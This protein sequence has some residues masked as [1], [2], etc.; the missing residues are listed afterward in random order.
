MASKP[1]IATKQNKAVQQEKKA[2]SAHQKKIGGS[3][4]TKPHVFKKINPSELPVIDINCGGNISHIK[5]ALTAYCQKELGAIS[6]I[7]IEG[8]YQD[9]ITVSYDPKSLDSDNDPLG[10]NK[11]RVI[12]KMKQADSDNAAYEKS[13]AKLF[14]ILSSMTTKEVDE[15]LSIHRSHLASDPT[16]TNSS[17]TA[18]STAA[19]DL[20]DSPPNVTAFINCPLTLWKD[21]VHVVT[22]KTAGNKRIDQDKVTVDFATM[23]QRQSESLS[24]FHHR[25]SHTVDSYEMLGLEKP[26]A[27][28]QAMR[29]IQGLDG[30]R[31]A[32]MQ[33][34]FANELHNGRDLYPTDLPTAVLKASRWMVSGRSTQ[35]PMRA[36]A[37]AKGGKD[38][39]GGKDKPKPQPKTDDKEKTSVKCEFCSR[40]GHVMTSC[41]KFKDA[42]TAATAATEEKSKHHAG[43]RKGTTMIARSSYKT[44]DSDDEEHHFLVNVHIQSRASSVLTASTRSA[45]RKT[46]IVL[47]TGANGSLF[48][49][50]SLLHNLDTQEEVTFD[51]I[52]GVLSTDTVGEFL[53]LCRA[54]VHRDAIANILSFSQL[55]QLGISIAYD[56]GENPDDDSFTILHDSG[57]LK[58]T[59]RENG[60]YV[61]DT[62]ASA[63]RTCL[64]T[65]VADNEALYSRRE[66]IRARE[67]R[68]LQRRMANP[69]DAKLIKA[70]AS[71]TIQ[72]TTVTPS[73]VT[74][75]TA[76]YGPS[77]EAIKGRTTTTHALPFPQE[78]SPRVTAEQK[79]Y[80]DIFFAAGCAF[81][82]SIVHPIGHIICSYLDKTDTPTLRRAL[83]T[84]LG[85][86]GQRRISIRHI[87]SD[88]EKG[89]LCMGQDFAGAGITLHLAGPGMHVHTVERAIRTI[90]EGVRGLLAGLPYPCPK[91]I[92]TH[93]IPFVAYRTNM[94]PSSTRTDNIPPFQL[95]FN[96]HINANI[97]CQ[98]EFGAYYQV[99]VRT[100]DNT[101]A[102][103]TLGAIGIGQSG[104]GTGTCTFYGLHN[105]AIFRAN[106]FR[107]LPMP[108]EVI[109][110]LT[111]LAAADKV[112]IP[113]DPIFQISA[114]TNDEVPD[115]SSDPSPSSPV[116]AEDNHQDLTPL[117]TPIPDRAPSPLPTTHRADD[118]PSPTHENVRIELDRRGDTPT[119]A[120]DITHEISEPQDDVPAPDERDTPLAADPPYNT[121]E[122]EPA[123]AVPMPSAKPPPMYVHPTRVR[124]PPEKLNLYGVYHMTAKRALKENPDGALP[125]IRQELETLLR[126]RVFHGRDYA[127]LTDPQRKS[128]IRSQMNVTQKY[129]P[130][131]DGNGRVKDK[132]KARLVGGGDG[133]DRN[134]YSRIDTSSPT[135]STSAILIIAQLAAA[136]RRHVI[137]LDI[138]SAYLNAKMPKDD[139]NKLVFMAIASNMADILI[140]LEPSY[141]RFQRSNGTI[142]VELDQA[143]YGCIES[144]LLWYKELSSFL[145]SIGFA[146]NPYEK[147][148][149]NK[150]ESGHQTTIA[151]YV[152]DLLITSTRPS[153][154]EAVVVALRD[155][156]KELK[157]TPGKIHNYL[158][159]V[160]DFSKPP[161]VIINQTGMI[162]DIISKVRAT[163]H[164]N[165]PSTD[166]K[167]PSIEQ[168]FESS[169]DSPLLSEEHKATFHSVVAKFNFVTCRARPD[170]L[171]PLSYLMKR[172]LKPTEED[173]R[174]LARYIAYAASTTD[175]PLRLGC[176]LPPRVNV[177]IDA[178]F[179]THPDMK[180]H[181]GVCITLGT[182]AYY[183]KSTTQKLN[184][185]SSCEAELVALAKGL[186]Q[187]LWSSYFIENQGYPSAPVT[188]LQDNQST[189]RLVENGG[190]TSELSRHIR[191][192][193]FWMRDLLIKNIISVVY[194]PT[195][196][197]IAD[198]MTKPL[199]GSLFRTMRDRIMGTAPCPMTKG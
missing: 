183:S 10:L 145:G 57:N 184:T 163:G 93:M 34:S 195:E 190:P 30:S 165:I 14:G 66:V 143:L 138:G 122:V 172:V 128:I 97:D 20:K 127:T 43:P 90:K 91:S 72:N 199:Q 39:K 55:R 22:T 185:T 53:G 32:T 130:S 126:K 167:S 193:F 196:S 123:S 174:K 154:A 164:F 162:E 61:H 102:P 103:R 109:A 21:I 173:G 18:T 25:M 166:P 80:V 151:I 179:A 23:R 153:H 107:L 59:H 113:K 134:L 125:V 101:V 36:L 116:P 139:P 137:S 78:D 192:G 115:S 31:Y 48:K 120:D 152:D 112:K 157:V 9:E 117:D 51:G 58:F 186:Q 44:Q 100:P 140:D 155:K 175:L 35:E 114:L 135:A 87:Y 49:N 159:M 106:T 33:T 160:M 118:L 150:E 60:L 148:I 69:P 11:A 149:L 28:T 68:Q 82:I 169:P 178:S 74:R 40:T 54:H 73:D 71:G 52:S 182:G 194:C 119:I 88:N 81:E 56:E 37:A 171:T 63:D 5:N 111:R 92:F 76:I 141:K 6:K 4:I 105:G 144:A 161:Y 38:N 16:T 15:K 84:H 41:F 133:Q 65:T 180:S 17:P 45:L 188:V 168:L 19:S 47:D 136:E 85:T 131:S 98:L 12:G 50:R 13:K 96:R 83:R 2:D 177:F 1:K 110:L 142:I 77:I 29:F 86:Y 89:I 187:G 181:S 121:V 67:A 170:M 79:M 24:D 3:D 197:M 75:A 191:I 46:D 95:I 147:C 26:P 104:N 156:Y 158:G 27:A 146:P 132:L 42:Q 7:F 62:R 176:H 124:R 94:F 198:I 108:S 70:L 189:I 99:P 8:R 64:V 129:A